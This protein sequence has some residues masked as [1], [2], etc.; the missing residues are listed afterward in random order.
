MKEAAS[1]LT[2]QRKQGREIS[3]VFDALAHLRISVF[4]DYPYLYDGSVDYEKTYLQ[5]YANAERALLFAALDGDQMVGA[6]TCIP[7]GDE[8]EDVQ[9]PFL[10]AGYDL[11]KIFYFGESILLPAYRGR[12][13]GHRFF[14]EREAHAASFGEY[15]WTCFC[16]VQRPEDHPQRPANYQPLD[17][18]WTKRGYRRVP[19]LQSQ[20]EWLD[21]GESIS[22]YK[23]MVYWLRPLP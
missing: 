14:D 7:L 13:L 5:T 3:E 19:D 10:K 4:R 18:F 9:A 8:T 11:S 17:A 23:P 20:F 16:A 21:V 1:N 12:G 2:F 15:A 6:T 22:T